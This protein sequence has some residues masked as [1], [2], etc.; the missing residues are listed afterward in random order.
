MINE[1]SYD[2]MNRMKN[3]ELPDVSAFFAYLLRFSAIAF[4]PF[5]PDTSFVGFGV[6]FY[7]LQIIENAYDFVCVNHFQMFSGDTSSQVGMK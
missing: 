1:C 3:A 4:L 7:L 6:S 2:F 5:I